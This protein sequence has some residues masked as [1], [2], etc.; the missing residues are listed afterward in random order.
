MLTDLSSS[1]VLTRSAATAAVA[2]IFPASAAAVAAAPERLR[3]LSAAAA[4]APGRREDDDRGPVTAAPAARA[5]LVLA[6]RSCAHTHTHTHAVVCHILFEGG[7][8]IAKGRMQTPTLSLSPLSSHPATHGPP[9]TPTTAAKL[10]SGKVSSSNPPSPTP[11]LHQSSPTCLVLLPCAYLPSDHQ[12]SAAQ[13]PCLPPATHLPPPHTDYSSDPS[14]LLLLPC[15]YL[16]QD[17][18]LLLQ[19]RSGA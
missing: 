11:P 14:Y 7:V 19:V 16:P 3:Q 18:S 5:D 9:P 15:A 1:L 10:T 4:R 6:S 12:P 2:D 13:S 8:Q 17:Q